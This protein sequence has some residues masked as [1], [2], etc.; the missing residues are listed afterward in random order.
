MT[1][2]KF[3]F[4]RWKEPRSA[5][6]TAPFKPPKSS[7]GQF[8]HQVFLRQ[9][10]KSSCVDSQLSYL[11]KYNPCVFSIVLYSYVYCI[12]ILLV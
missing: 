2:I 5:V 8:L 12:N 7:P 1:M 6:G 3:L 11:F 4:S 10:L 9:F